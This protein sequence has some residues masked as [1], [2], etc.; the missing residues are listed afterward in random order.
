MNIEVRP[1]ALGDWEVIVEYNV[2][3]ARESEATHL[4]R[5]T[6]RLGVRALLENPRHG[7]YFIA[8][9]E[10]RVVGQLMHTREWSDWRNGEIWWIQSV[11]VHPDFRRQGV[12]R[13]LYQH[14]ERLASSEPGIV[15]LRLYVEEQNN[16]A[17]ST[18]TALGLLH[19]GYAVMERMFA[20][21]LE[22]PLTGTPRSPV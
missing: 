13:T 2:A 9:M 18:Y 5:E 16:R 22:P 17:I 6:V 14:L 20:A 12:F 21:P 11:F 19:S 7:R 8:V 3:L 1:A 15:G 4:N 10:G